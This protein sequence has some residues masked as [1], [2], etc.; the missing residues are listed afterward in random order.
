MSEKQIIRPK[1]PKTGDKNIKSE[2]DKTSTK[3]QKEEI[4]SSLYPSKTKSAPEIKPLKQE[5]KPFP[6]TESEI[7][8][9]SRT[10]NIKQIIT[11]QNKEQQEDL[12]GIKPTVFQPFPTLSESE[13]AISPEISTPLQ[14]EIVPSI[15]DTIDQLIE[16]KE[17]PIEKLEREYENLS[18]LEKSVLDIAKSILKKKKY[19]S[20]L[21]VD[22]VETMSPLVEQLYSKC[23]ARLT[24]TQGF[25]KESIFAC[26]KDLIQNKWMVTEQRR[27][28]R[29]ILQAE[30]LK[31][32]LNFIHEHP[33]THARDTLIEEELHITRNPFIKHVMVLEAFGLVRSKR[34]GRTQNY[35][36]ENVPE[37]F[38]D[39]VV[40][41][42]N[43]LVTNILMILIKE[44]VGL[45]EVARRLGVYHGA[46]QYHIKNLISMNLINKVDN[47]LNVNTE[48]L[49]RYNDLFKVPPFGNVMSL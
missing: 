33:G 14:N 42:L 16:A 36:L 24:H 25:S 23:I 43:P 3:S 8:E 41:F 30:T 13:S 38:D 18:T 20:S 49:R 5:F 22:R 12:K 35:F 39:F 26:I 37:I 29:E 21:E 19:N 4:I 44:K 32:V 27:T 10:K 2:E 1:K 17:N 9:K 11:H 7:D 6:G 34:I 31:N 46:I 48:L 47:S 15:D 28:R 40:L 45:S